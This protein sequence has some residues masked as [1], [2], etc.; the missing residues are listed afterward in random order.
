MT[1][2]LNRCFSKDDLQMANRNK[3]ICMILLIIKEIQSKPQWD[4]I[5]HLSDDNKLSKG[6]KIRKIGEKNVKR[7]IHLCIVG[8]VSALLLGQPLHKTMWRF[9]KKLNIWLLYDPTILLHSINLKEIK[10]LIQKYKCT[11][12]FTAAYLLIQYWR[13]GNRLSVHSWIKG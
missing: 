13:Y 9:F 4:V 7:S 12:I 6:Q 11:P 1:E 8:G 3:K 2:Y 10:I 5:S